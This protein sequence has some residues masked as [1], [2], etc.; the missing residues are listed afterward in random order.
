MQ[1]LKM[2]SFFVSARC[3]DSLQGANPSSRNSSLVDIS[4]IRLRV[5]RPSPA[6]AAWVIN[7]QDE[8]FVYDRTFITRVKMPVRGSGF[9][10]FEVPE[11]GTYEIHFGSEFTRSYWEFE[12]EHYRQ[13][14]KP[15]GKPLGNWYHVDAGLSAPEPNL[16]S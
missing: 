14:N 1:P 10:A 6:F 2:E 13:E 15:G 3:T 16:E 7:G 9:A 12:G 8:E 5:R 11:G 4:C